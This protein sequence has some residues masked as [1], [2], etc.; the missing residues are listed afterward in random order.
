MAPPL[1]KELSSLLLRWLQTEEDARREVF[2]HASGAGTSR[3]SVD[4]HSIP[5]HFASNDD[6]LEP[7]VSEHFSGFPRA[8]KPTD[9]NLIH[10][11][12]AAPLLSPEVVQTRPSAG[13]VM[14]PAFGP[15][16]ILSTHLLPGGW[17]LVEDTGTL[18]VVSEPDCRVLLVT[19]SGRSQASGR[20]RTRQAMPRSASRLSEAILLLLALQEL[21]AMFDATLVH[22]ACV[23]RQGRAIL[24]M[25]TERRGKSTTAFSLVR[26][27]W[28]LLSDDRSLL[29]RDGETVSLHSF[30]ERCRIG[31]QGISFFPEVAPHAELPQGEGKA[32]F[33]PEAVWGNVRVS[34]A[35]PAVLLIPEVVDQDL[36]FSQRALRVE[37]V[38]DMKLLLADNVLRTSPSAT[39]TRFD[40]LCELLRSVPVFRLRVGP[41]IERT[42]SD[43]Q[44]ILDGLD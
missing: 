28:S 22:G 37:H 39:A 18:V 4:Y 17:I 24:I 38:D 14:F 15:H 6:S 20:L 31:A 10:L 42:A 27:G 13:K 23:A 3:L 40:L 5:L 30:L 41:G 34:A 35:R 8:S 2:A 11:H 16:A 44:R 33:D 7:L 21:L 25:A 12:S 19:V 32:E 29:M 9:A 1:A 36:P 43:A 26:A